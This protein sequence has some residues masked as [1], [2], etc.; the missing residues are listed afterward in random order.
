[1]LGFVFGHKSPPLA[2]NRAKIWAFEMGSHDSVFGRRTSCFGLK[3][4]QL[5]LLLRSSAGPSIAISMVRVV[6]RCEKLSDFF[7]RRPLISIN[8]KPRFGELTWEATRADY[9]NPAPWVVFK[10]LTFQL[11]VAPSTG[12]CANTNA[13]HNV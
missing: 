3:S 1:M 10:H 7:A 8:V 9:A 4:L 5:P 2:H 12:L 11:K 6:P 13:L